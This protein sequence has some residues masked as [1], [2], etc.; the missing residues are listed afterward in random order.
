MRRSTGVK[1][2]HGKEIF[3]GDT[4]RIGTDG[5]WEYIPSKVEWLEIGNCW[6]LLGNQFEVINA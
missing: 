3:E 5:F 2:I 4:V 6:N 1:D